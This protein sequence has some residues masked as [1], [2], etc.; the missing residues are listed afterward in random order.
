MRGPDLDGGSRYR[1]YS[2]H[3]STATKSRNHT[4]NLSSITWT[5]EEHSAD[6]PLSTP[7]NSN[8]GC[9]FQFPHLSRVGS[10]HPGAALWLRTSVLL[11]KTGSGDHARIRRRGSHHRRSCAEARPRWDTL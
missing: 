7:G 8:V 4:W 10:R 9:R 11:A 1:D 2:R 6:F 3:R 5:G